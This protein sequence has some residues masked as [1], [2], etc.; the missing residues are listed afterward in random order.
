LIYPCDSPNKNWDNSEEAMKIRPPTPPRS[1]NNEEKNNNNSGSN[2]N[3]TKR[4][5][6]FN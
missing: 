1:R 4:K 2:S 5:D 3:N 6:S